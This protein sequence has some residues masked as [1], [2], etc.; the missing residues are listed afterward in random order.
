M[1]SIYQ[2]VLG[3]DFGR[4]HPEIQRRFSLTSA[5]GLAWCQ[6]PL[7]TTD[8][9][10]SYKNEGGEIEGCAVA[11]AGALPS[12]AGVASL[13][14]GAACVLLRRRRKPTRPS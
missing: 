3:S 10:D 12:G 7:A 1:T 13:L 6:Y 14:A 8:F 9:W 5:S 2:Q 4:L 11:D